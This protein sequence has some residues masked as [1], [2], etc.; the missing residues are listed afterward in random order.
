MTGGDPYLGNKVV[1][2]VIKG[3]QSC[4]VM[5]NAKHWVEN[6][7]EEDRDTVSEVRYTLSIWTYL[8]LLSFFTF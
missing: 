2:P 1:Q 6:N 7:Q 8:N 5:A 3:I 4:G